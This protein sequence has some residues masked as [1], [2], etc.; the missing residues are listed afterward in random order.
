MCISGL[1]KLNL[2]WRFDFWLKPSFAICLAAPKK[3]LFTYKVVKS[4]LSSL[5]KVR[6]ESL[7]HT[8]VISGEHK[9][10]FFTM[11]EK[12]GFKSGEHICF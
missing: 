10:V 9:I 11:L 2:T 6:S 3:I 4:G 5:T 8:L 12:Q 7:I 1:D